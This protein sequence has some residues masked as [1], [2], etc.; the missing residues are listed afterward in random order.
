MLVKEQWGIEN[1]G[2]ILAL[3]NAF[4]K[5]AF[6]VIVNSLWAQTHENTLQTTVNSCVGHK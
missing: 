6:Q 5:N 4:Y 3:F 1:A 2:P